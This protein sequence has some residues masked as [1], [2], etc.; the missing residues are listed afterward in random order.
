MVVHGWCVLRFTVR[1]I[2]DDPEMVIATGRAALA[3]PALIPPS[4]FNP[5][6]SLSA[7]G[8]PGWRWRVI[9]RDGSEVDAS[10]GL[11]ERSL[12]PASVPP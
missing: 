12:E 3:I 10:A 7:A 4:V 5:R 8:G 2:E 1:M 6:C 9:V 11:P